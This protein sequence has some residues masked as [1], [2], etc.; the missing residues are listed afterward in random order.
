[1]KGDCNGMPMTVQ[2]S[3]YGRPVCA[4]PPAPTEIADVPD[5]R[6]LQDV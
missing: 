2:P 4:R 6:M 1:M 3:Q 5:D